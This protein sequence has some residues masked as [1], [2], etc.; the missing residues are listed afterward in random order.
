MGTRPRS[1]ISGNTYIGLRYSEEYF[2]KW[3]D[4]EGLDQSFLH[5]SINHPA[6]DMSRP[7]VK[8][9]QPAPQAG[10]STKELSRRPI[11]A[12]LES[13]QLEVGN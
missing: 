12:Y 9:R 2:K 6:T 11:A 5:P 13:L 7:R 10:Q 1:F 8:P 4:M 3:T